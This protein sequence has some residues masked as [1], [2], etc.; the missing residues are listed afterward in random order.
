MGGKT[1]HGDLHFLFPFASKSLEAYI[2]LSFLFVL[3]L[4]LVG[5]GSEQALTFLS[6]SAST[7]CT[8]SQ[9]LRVKRVAA[10]RLGIL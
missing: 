4:G 6:F 3:S 8:C 5:F 2:Y 9:N 1:L 10:N 7:F